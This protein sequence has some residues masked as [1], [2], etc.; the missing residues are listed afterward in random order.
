VVTGGGFGQVKV[1]DAAGKVTADLDGGAED[2][3]AVAFSPDGRYVAHCG[4]QLTI[5]ET[6][7]FEVV[8]TPDKPAK[9]GTLGAF[10][11]DGKTLVGASAHGEVRFLSVSGWKET[12]HRTAVPGLEYYSPVVSPD[13]KTLAVG[14]LIRAKAGFVFTTEVWAVSAPKL[15]KKRF[16]VADNHLGM[17]FTPDGRYLLLGEAD[18]AAGHKLL[19]IRAWDVGSGKEVVSWAAGDSCIRHLAVSPDGTR[20]ISCHDEWVARVWDLKAILGNK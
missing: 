13:G 2:T 10:F 20:L 3:V 1:W 14:T 4:G 5:R 19:R 6:A 7:K 17:A 8:A 15:E 11:P 16:E 9:F 12:T 18:A